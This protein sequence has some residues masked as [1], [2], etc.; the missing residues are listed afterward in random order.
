MV[1]ITVNPTTA[2]LTA[3]GCNP[4]TIAPGAST[5]CTVTLSSG[6]PSG[7]ALVSIS[8]N[9][10]FVT[11]PG[12]IT[13]PQAAT[14]STFTASAS[15][16]APASNVSITS[17]YAGVTINTSILVA[18][19]SCS[20]PTIHCVSS[21]AGPTQ[22]FSTIQAAANIA[23]PGD[24]ILVYPGNYAGFQITR[25]GTAAAPITFKT[26]GSVV[27]NQSASTGDGITLSNVNYIV[28]DGFQIQNS[29]QFCIASHNGSP[30]APMVGLTIRNNACTGGG[31][32]GFYLSE[33]SYSLIENNS[34]SNPVASHGLY[35]ANAGSDNTTIRGNTI[36]GVHGSDANGI[37]LNGDKSV[38]G[39]G[40]ITNVVIENNVV[41]D[42]FANGISLD[43]VQ[44]AVFRNNLVYSV[45]RN[46][47]R[48][49]R[50]DGAQGPKNY[51]IVNNTF[52]A[53]GDWAIKLSEDLGGHTV[54][55][56]ILLT[57]SSSAGSI[58]VQKTSNVR[59]GYNAVV[60]R[61][62]SNNNS[63]IALAQ[64]Q[65]SGNDT[66]SFV[67]TPA[68]LFVNP[69]GGNYQLLSTAPA[70]DKGTASFNKIAAP[71]TDL[72]GGSRPQGTGFD[73]GAYELV[74]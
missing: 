40:L 52:V 45:S 53:T 3:V 48:A 31:T 73:I 11:V 69:G 17:T 34:I 7:G 10:S 68:A 23:L 37:H 24:T 21:T 2:T 49:Y 19:N 47:F 20:D 22:E 9:N 6:A 8:D 70:V 66:T 71:T 62:S 12:S 32:G 38:G 42:V 36:H 57:S 33:A 74:Q 60:N 44:N 50:I 28:I 58:S 43:G 59:S 72:M 65:Q 29:S 26:A 35:L 13:V 27:I 56:N 25:S 64:W 61:F 14:T 41:Y 5:T 15:S 54:F 1:A 18:S 55:N 4:T 46:A 30:T 67:T 39:N 16:S 63:I 51:T